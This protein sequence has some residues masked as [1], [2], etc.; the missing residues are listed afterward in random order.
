MM[1]VQRDRDAENRERNKLSN[2]P[3]RAQSNEPTDTGN[4]FRVFCDAGQASYA[5][6][7]EVSR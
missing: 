6:D 2:G 3:R 4:R 1:P 7:M 5:G